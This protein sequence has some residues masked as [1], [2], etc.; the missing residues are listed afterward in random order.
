MTSYKEYLISLL[1][2]MLFHKVP[3]TPTMIFCIY[4]DH[5]SEKCNIIFMEKTLKLINFFTVKVVG[6]G[7]I[8]CIANFPLFIA[9][10]IHVL[11]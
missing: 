7:V 8:R 11:K 9:P 3:L 5:S 2:S 6:Y 4:L 10:K 1:Y